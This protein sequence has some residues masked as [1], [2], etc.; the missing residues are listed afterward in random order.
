MRLKAEEIN[1]R[2]AVLFEKLGVKEIKKKEMNYST[3]LEMRKECLL[4][5]GNNEVMVGVHYDIGEKEKVQ[6]LGEL[7]G[8]TA[9]VFTHH[10]PPSFSGTETIYMQFEI[11]GADLL[12]SVSK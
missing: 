11:D 6:I 10:F 3:C 5:L 4:T 1:D 2:T 12:L 7:D 8:Y 9:N